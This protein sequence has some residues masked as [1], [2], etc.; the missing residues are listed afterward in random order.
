VFKGAMISKVWT[1]P[2]DGSVYAIRIA[3][4]MMTLE[5][6]RI[7]IRFVTLLTNSAVL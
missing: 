2:V 1:K 3:A 5:V 6:H 7:E 4:E